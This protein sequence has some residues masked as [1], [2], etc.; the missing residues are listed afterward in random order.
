MP[1]VFV[2]GIATSVAAVHRLLPNTVSS[3]LCME[4][5]Q[6]PPSTE[7]LTLVINQVG[8]RTSNVLNVTV[9]AM[10]T[11]KNVRLIFFSKLYY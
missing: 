5:F 8:M 3:L 4:K 6:A 9:G 10:V 11:A 7:Y 1:I 2:F